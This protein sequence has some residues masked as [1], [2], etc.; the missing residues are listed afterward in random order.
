MEEKWKE[1]IEDLRKRFWVERRE[2]E[3][4]HLWLSST[5]NLSPFHHFSLISIASHTSSPPFHL[6]IKVLQL[7]WAQGKQRRSMRRWLQRQAH[8]GGKNVIDLRG[9]NALEVYIFIYTYMY[10]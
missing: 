9:N 3:T 4:C 10:L 2:D 1:E 6:L 5:S 8:D 7:L